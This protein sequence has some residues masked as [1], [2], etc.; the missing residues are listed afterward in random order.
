MTALPDQQEVMADLADCIISIYALES[1]ILR[2]RKIALRGSSTAS[3]AAI[4]AAMCT[5]FSEVAL[6]T[7]E[8]AAR[9]VLAASA[10]GDALGIQ[11]GVLRRFAKVGPAAVD[12]ISVNRQ[13]A[14][15]FIEMGRYRI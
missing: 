12:D 8:Q 9:R 15:H 13:V 3:S 14:R 4:A 7:V 2:A 6:A 10:E 11:L 1:A 5:S